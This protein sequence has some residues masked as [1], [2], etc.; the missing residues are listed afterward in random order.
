[1]Q[2]CVLP[3]VMTDHI[4]A[5]VGGNE[6]IGD[7]ALVSVGYSPNTHERTVSLA[8]ES[9]LTASGYNE[10]ATVGGLDA[11]ELPDG[12]VLGGEPSGAEPWSAGHDDDAAYRVTV[13]G[14]R[15]VISE[16]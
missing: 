11:V 6:R 5:P 3:N 2:R 8:E 1:M 4:E 9:G 14:A 13:D 12:A 16:L 15:A 10:Y 7:A